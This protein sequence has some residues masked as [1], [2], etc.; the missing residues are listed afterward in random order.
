[1]TNDGAALIAAERKTHKKKG[2]DNEHDDAEHTEGELAMAAACYAASAVGE[3][4][5]VHGERLVQVNSSRGIDDNCYSYPQ[6]E[7]TGYWDPFPW[8]DDD[9]RETYD[10]IRKLVVAGSLI[11]AEIDHLQRTEGGE[12]ETDKR[13]WICVKCGGSFPSCGHEEGALANP[14]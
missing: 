2:W 5:L 4:I 12:E 13:S 14:A 8:P 6:R 10:K 9:K 1:M 3:E 11:A 7:E